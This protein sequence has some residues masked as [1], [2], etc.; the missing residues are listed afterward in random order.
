MLNKSSR[1][2]A[3]ANMTSATSISNAFL[4]DTAN[5]PSQVWIIDTGA[6][7]HMVSDLR[8]LS[9]VEEVKSNS[10]RKVHLPN[11]DVVLVKHIGTCPISARSIIRKVLYVP[12]FRYNLLSV[13]KLTKDLQCCIAF[14]PDF[15]LFQDLLQWEGKRDW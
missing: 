3:S 14:Y 2:S 1:T 5:K 8:A 10:P 15:C 12:Q 4:V 7:N 13:S 11:G 6:T 9:T